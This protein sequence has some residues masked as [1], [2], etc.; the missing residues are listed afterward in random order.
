MKQLPLAVVGYFDA[1]EPA[2][3]LIIENQAE[4]TYSAENCPTIPIFPNLQYDTTLT[5]LS[6]LRGGE[7]Q[8]CLRTYF[9][10]F[11][12]FLG[13][14]RCEIPTQSYRCGEIICEN[15]LLPNL[16]KDSIYTLEIPQALGLNSYGYVTFE[17]QVS[18][19]IGANLVATNDRIC[20]AINMGDLA[21]NNILGD[22]TS[23]LYN[24]YCASSIAEPSPHQVGV[25]WQ[26]NVATWFSFT[27]SDDPNAVVLIEAISDPENANDPVNLQLALYQTNDNTCEGAL[28]ML[29]ES[30]DGNDFDEFLVL[31]CLIPNTPYFLMVDGETTT[32]DLLHGVFGLQISE[33]PIQAQTNDDICN[34][35]PIDIGTQNVQ[36][37]SK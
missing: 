1:G 15:V 24:N 14:N 23:N 7:I 36:Q 8:L 28:L 25:S 3:G 31:S 11:T 10:E 22:K 2:I 20:H 19:D 6:D 35:I 16:G 32:N 13:G 26:N 34:A 33:V 21:Q 29:E 12:G 17:I 27:T 5:C 4:I 18:E 9:R 30:F 37:F